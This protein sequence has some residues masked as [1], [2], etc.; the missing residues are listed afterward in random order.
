MV[1]HI[2]SAS[3][4]AHTY[5]CVTVYVYMCKHAIKT[6]LE[7]CIKVGKAELR[8]AEI[9]VVIWPLTHSHVCGTMCL[10]ILVGFFS[11]SLHFCCS[12]LSNSA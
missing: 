7:V 11:H 10:R 3:R 9:Q 2:A 12:L 1:L 8:S 4:L 5:V 6:R